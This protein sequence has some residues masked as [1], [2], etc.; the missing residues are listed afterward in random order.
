[1]PVASS[2][3][4]VGRLAVQYPGGIAARF[5]WAGSGQGDAVFGISEAAGSLADFGE[6]AGANHER[7]CRAELRVES[8]AGAWTARFAS[9]IFDEPQG[10]LWDEHSLLLIKYGFV[11]YALNSRSG[12]LVWVRSTGTPAIAV[13]ASTRLDHVLL[14]TELE[15]LAMRSDGEVAWRAAHSEVVTDAQITAGRLDLTTYGGMHLYL[16]ARTGEQA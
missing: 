13:L 6:H 12:E 2:Q 3:P 8:P 11:L 10:V 16:D 5:R 9:P 4:E 7:L 15:T 14:Q 1:V